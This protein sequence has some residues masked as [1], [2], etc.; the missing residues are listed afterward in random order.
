MALHVNKNTY[1]REKNNHG[2]RVFLSGITIK[3]LFVASVAEGL[4]DMSLTG[5]AST[6]HKSAVKKAR[7]YQQGKPF[8]NHYYYTRQC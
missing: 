8:F 1:Q 4:H 2:T 7:L 5:S 6:S 3:K